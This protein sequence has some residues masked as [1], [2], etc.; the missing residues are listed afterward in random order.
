YSVII[1]AGDPF[2]TG[3]SLAIYSALHDA[4]RE[5][6]RANGIDAT[7]ANAISPKISE[8]CFANAVRA[9]VI[10]NVRKIADAAHR[11][12]RSVL[13]HQGSIQTVDL[14]N[15][16]LDDFARNL[17]DRFVR[18]SFSQELFDRAIVIAQTKYGTREWLTR[19]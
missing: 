1:P 6:L 5:A 3:S 8:D 13:L 2:F 16:F 7:L 18:K 19:W 10:S 11:R 9:D 4:I 15:R 14:P 17:C 12:C